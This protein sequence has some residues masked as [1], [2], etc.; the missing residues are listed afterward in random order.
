MSEK[1]FVGCVNTVAFILFHSCFSLGYERLI[2]CISCN[3]CVSK[4]LTA[5]RGMLFRLFLTKISQCVSLPVRRCQQVHMKQLQQENVFSIVK[6]Y[7]DYVYRNAGLH[8]SQSNSF[9]VT[10]RYFF[11][12][13][14]S[15]FLS[16]LL[17]LF[18]QTS[19]YLLIVLCLSFVLLNRY[20]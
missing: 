1:C 14:F 18:L 19:V 17:A 10:H 5:N 8:Q 4:A 3:C 7:I 16:L 9:Q 20:Y 2:C 15:H 12:P 13:F 6:A 11:L